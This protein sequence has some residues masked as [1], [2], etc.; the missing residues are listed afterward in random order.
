MSLFGFTQHDDID[1]F[2][3]KTK[4]YAKEYK[5]YVEK[6]IADKKFTL[7]KIEDKK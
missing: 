1:T 3:P 7:H 2:Y 5:A 6:N 4:Y